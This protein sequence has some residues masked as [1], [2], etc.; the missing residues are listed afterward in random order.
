VPD[1]LDAVALDH[2][3]RDRAF[4]VAALFDGEIDQHAAGLH[5]RSCASDTSRGAGRPGISAGG[6]DD[7]LLG[8]VAD[9][10]SACL[11]L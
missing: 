4:D 6:D 3:A 5:R 7:V 8:D 10:S 1:D 2:L 11:A 9:T